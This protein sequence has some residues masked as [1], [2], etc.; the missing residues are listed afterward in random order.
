M[1]RSLM[2]ELLLAFVLVFR[3]DCLKEPLLMVVRVGSP[4]TSIPISCLIRLMRSSRSSLSGSQYL[5]E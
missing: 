5:G 4:G 3:A 2:F 1:I